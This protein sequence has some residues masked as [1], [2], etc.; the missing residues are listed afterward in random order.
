VEIQD[1]IYTDTARPN[2]ILKQ[3]PEPD[4][5][6]KVNR[7]V[8]LTLNRSVPPIVEMPNLIGYSIRNAEMNLKNAGL[9]LGDTSYRSD[10]ARNAVLE[11]LYNGSSIAPGTKVRMGSRI[12]FVLGSGVGKSEF[13]VPDIIGMTFGEAK[14]MLEANGISFA[15]VLPTPD[16]SDTNAAYIYWQSPQR[17]N[18]DKKLQHIRSGQTMDVRLQVERPVRDSTQTP[19]PLPEEE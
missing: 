7:K 5:V 12:S 3:F 16:V 9:K 17:F 14:S 8:F 11:Q 15:V 4:E 19:V 1:S 13:A 10:F 18:E 6:V 2:I